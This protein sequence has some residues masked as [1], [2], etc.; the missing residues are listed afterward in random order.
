MLNLRGA[1]LLWPSPVRVVMPGN[2]KYR[3]AVGSQA[4]MVLMTALLAACL[5]LYLVSGVGFRTGLQHLLGN[6]D[7]ARDA[8]I[9][10]AGTQWFT[11]EARGD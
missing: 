5:A 1:D 6:F 2:R 9:E 11:L 4:E 7:L 3:M 10:K 8:F